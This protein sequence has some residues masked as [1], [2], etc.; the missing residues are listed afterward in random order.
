M[1]K[2]ARMYFPAVTSFFQGFTSFWHNFDIQPEKSGVLLKVTK[3]TA[4]LLSLP[5]LLML[6]RQIKKKK[7]RGGVPLC[8][9]FGD[10]ENGFAS[11]LFP[12]ELGISWQPTIDFEGVVWTI[13]HLKIKGTFIF[14]ALLLLPQAASETSCSCVLNVR[15]ACYIGCVTYQLQLM[16]VCS[17]AYQLHV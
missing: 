5:L 16:S 7:R 4:E 10:Y 3:S 15:S 9:D 12:V 6:C 14:W 13:D 8:P 11:T 2:P 1:K 17:Y